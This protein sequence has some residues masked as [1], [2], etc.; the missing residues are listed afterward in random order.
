[1]IPEANDFLA[2]SNALYDLIAANTDGKLQETTAFKHWSFEDIIRH[3]HVWNKMAYT[4]LMDG[5]KFDAEFQRLAAGL[6]A[7]GGL[8]VPERLYMGD[9]A[10][11]ELLQLWHE[12]AS[13][14]T[15]AFAQTD[16]EQRVPWAGPPMSAQS[17]ITARLM[18]TWSHAQ[19]I[20][21]ALGVERKNT[22]RI[23]S[24]AE[25]GVRTYRWTFANRQ[26]EAPMPKPHIRLTAPSGTV[27]TWN[28]ESD[29]D[30]VS[31]DATEFC[32]VVTQSRN[33]ADTHLVVKGDSARAW[34]PIAQCFAGPV[35][36]PPAQGE[37]AAVNT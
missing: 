3:L 36:T 33:I 29:T 32:Q 27:W 30:Y 9:I 7:D 16:P 18:E 17:S 19:A 26:M 10:G 22:D 1:M 24:I 8:R 6:G 15:S 25:L 14:L 28:D 4:S 23:R 2:E 21:D 34:M 11:G 12:Y 5:E 35:E 31:G 37:R 20:Y 13:E